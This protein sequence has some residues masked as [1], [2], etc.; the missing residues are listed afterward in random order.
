MLMPRSSGTTRCL[1]KLL[2]CYDRSNIVKIANFGRAVATDQLCYP[3]T[4]PEASVSKCRV[5]HTLRL[6]RE[7]ET[8]LRHPNWQLLQSD[9]SRSTADVC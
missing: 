2:G 8:D 4:I 6:P 1:S 5:D 3:L 7:G 9:Q